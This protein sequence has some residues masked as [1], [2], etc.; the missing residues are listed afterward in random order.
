MFTQ[1]TKQKKCRLKKYKVTCF[2]KTLMF[3]NCFYFS[4]QNLFSRTNIIKKNNFILFGKL[5]EKKKFQEQN[6]KNLFG[7]LSKKRFSRPKKKKNQGSYYKII[8]VGIHF[9]K[10]STNKLNI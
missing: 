7:L 9:A 3:C 10:L 4:F 8:M 6:K 5:R 2:I 1:Q